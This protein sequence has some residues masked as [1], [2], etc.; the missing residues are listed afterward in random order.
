MKTGKNKKVTNYQPKL[1]RIFSDTFKRTRV[2]EIEQGLVTIHQVSQAYSVSDNAVR[3][4]IKKYSRVIHPGVRQV[5]E[6]KSE[7]TRTLAL[8]KRVEEL[9]RTIGQ[10][11]LQIDYYER[12]LLEA[13]EELGFDVKKNIDGTFSNGSMQHSKRSGGS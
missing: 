4:W 1:T 9:E 11:Q 6:L 5:V 2:E 12:L 13:S 3:N 10:K 8:Q 7:A